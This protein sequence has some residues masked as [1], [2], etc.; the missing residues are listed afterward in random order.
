MAESRTFVCNQC[1]KNIEEWSDGNPYYIDSKGLKHYAYHPD[2]EKLA[3]CIGNDVPHLSL[4]CGYEFK[5]DSRAPVTDCRKCYSENIIGT[6]KLNGEKCPACSKGS[7]HF[8]PGHF[9][10]S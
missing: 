7:F 4:S 8:A 6:Y 1:N 3:K 5:V 2:H 9:T 10:V